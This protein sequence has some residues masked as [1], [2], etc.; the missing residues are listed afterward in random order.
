MARRL[1]AGRRVHWTKPR[2]ESGCSTEGTATSIGFPPVRNVAQPR[3]FARSRGGWCGPSGSNGPD[4][5]KGRPPL[6]LQLLRIPEPSNQG[7]RR[8]CISFHGSSQPLSL[9]AEGP[10]GVSYGPRSSCAPSA[11]TPKQSLVAL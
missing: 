8:P 4:L 6:G 1:R 5:E 3:S 2:P 11:F 9:E 10:N 7:D